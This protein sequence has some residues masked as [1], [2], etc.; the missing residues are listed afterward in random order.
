[1]K[2]GIAVD[3][4]IPLHIPSFSA[5]I[6]AHSQSIRCSAISAP[7]RFSSSELEY[8]VEIAKLGAALRAEIKNY[9]VSMLVTTIPFANNYFYTGMGSIF[10]ISLSDWHL[11]T[12]LPMSNGLAF[13][14]CQI[15]S[16]Y[17]L[18]IGK[19]HDESTGCINDFCW[20]KTGVD[21]QMRAA[22]ICEH[23]RAHSADNPQLASDEFADVVSI[24]N[25]ISL[26]SR[27]GVDIL[28]ESPLNQSLPQS[29]I[30]ERFELL[31]V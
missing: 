23:C 21:V 3:N 24:L 10:I 5:F 15:I 20:D 29:S 27:R 31:P 8:E 22:F 19:N 14:L 16:K 12:T 1:M 6:Q 2:I 18:N 11:L 4:T 9:D 30:P 17:F 28:S 13:M 7:L 26:S 25:A